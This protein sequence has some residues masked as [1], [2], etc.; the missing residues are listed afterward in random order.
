MPQEWKRS[1]EVFT[2]H[3]DLFRLNIRNTSEC[4]I[5]S[6]GVQRYR[7]IIFQRPRGTA[8]SNHTHL[9]NIYVEVQ[10]LTCDFPKFGDSENYTIEIPENP[11]RQAKLVS[12]SVWGALR[13][14]ETL[15]QLVY[16]NSNGSYLINATQI[17]DWPQFKY[18]GL[19]LDTARHFIPVSVLLQNLV[20]YTSHPS[21]NPSLVWAQD[22][23]N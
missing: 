10:D 11:F 4:D 9:Y 8:S 15:S 19:L 23:I 3:P 7:E 17:S 5:Q 12:Q 13:G 16:Q 21:L 2:I 22:S 6:E 18:R 20:R 14:L 1:E